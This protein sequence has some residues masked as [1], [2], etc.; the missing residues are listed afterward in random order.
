MTAEPDRYEDVNNLDT[1]KA[2]YGDQFWI[3]LIE[4]Y[5]LYVEM[6]DR[7]S[8]RRSQ[9]NGFYISLLTGLLAILSIVADNDV[10]SGN[11]PIVFAIVGLLGMALCFLWRLYIKA[12]A[13]LVW[14]KIQ[15]IQD[16]EKQ[17][18]YPCYIRENRLRDTDLTNKDT[19]VRHT[20]IEQY[21]A[22]AFG[23]L[24]FG[25]FLY[26]IAASLG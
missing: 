12:Y 17:L 3:A 22:I 26:S 1:L 5:K 7:I 8:A 14:R 9:M 15:V 13:R 11:Q 21:T 2:Q 10:F 6:H 19:Y 20:T 24:Y 25:L 23:V 4:Q 16:M 18:P